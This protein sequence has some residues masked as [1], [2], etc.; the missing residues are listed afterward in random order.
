M[1]PRTFRCTP[2]SL[3]VPLHITISSS[4]S[5]VSLSSFHRYHHYYQHQVCFFDVIIPTFG[6]R[7][8]ASQL[9]LL[10]PVVAP[11]GSVSVDGL[12]RDYRN[13]FVAEG[14]ASTAGVS[15]MY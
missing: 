9:Q 14:A 2:F 12:L 15:I 8:E 3:L 5:C 13:D 1:H 6:G 4:L 7:T 10:P 11:L